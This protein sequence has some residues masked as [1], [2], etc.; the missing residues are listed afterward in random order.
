MVAYTGSQSS[1]VSLRPRSN[2][3]AH[4]NDISVRFKTPKRSGVLFAATSR[5]YNDHIRAFLDDGV[6][7]VDANVGRVM[8]VNAPVLFC[9]VVFCSRPRSEGWPHHTEYTDIAKFAV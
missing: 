9:S 7:K 4:T 1:V 6:L 8:Q 5:G 2:A 3:A